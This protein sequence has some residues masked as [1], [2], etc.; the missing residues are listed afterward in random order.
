LVGTFLHAAAKIFFDTKPGWSGEISFKIP[1]LKEGRADLMYRDANGNGHFWEIK[2]VSYR[3]GVKHHSAQ[4]QVA[5]YR[6]LAQIK[7]PD[8][9]YSIGTQGGG[10]VPI[11]GTLT[12]PFTDGIYNYDAKLFIPK[13]E[14]HK[15]IIYYRLTNQRLTPEAQ[16]AI[17]VAKDAAKVGAVAA[18][19][20]GAILLAPETGGGSV[21]A[22]SIVIGTI[23]TPPQQQAQPQSVTTQ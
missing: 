22:G 7:D 21:V 19:V 23:L 11:Q 5:R 6:A 9:K 3:V 12:L 10:P 20:V 14:A 2:P 8:H 16:K 18:V 13:G 15:G 17:E 4:T 1:G